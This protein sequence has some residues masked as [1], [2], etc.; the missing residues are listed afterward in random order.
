M[1]VPTALK[2]EGQL[3]RGEIYALRTLIHLCGYVRADNSVHPEFYFVRNITGIDAHTGAYTGVSPSF[4]VSE[5]FW[6]RDYTAPETRNALAAGGQQVYINGYPAGRI[7]YLALM[8][9]FG[10]FLTAVWSEPQ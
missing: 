5:D 4:Q 8:E 6:T 10:E 3:G 9:H 2:V 1:K 7:G